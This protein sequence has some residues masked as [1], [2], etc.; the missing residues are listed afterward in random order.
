MPSNKHEGGC[1]TRVTT[2]LKDQRSMSLCILDE[3]M[4]K[5]TEQMG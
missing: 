5:V 2:L 1:L 3:A 4:N